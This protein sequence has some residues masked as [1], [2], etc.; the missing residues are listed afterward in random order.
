MSKISKIRDVGVAKKII[1][2]EMITEI[3]NYVRN[4]TI[5]TFNIN[6]YMNCY[7]I[8]Q[9]VADI[10]DYESDYLFNYH[11]KI[12]QGYIEECSQII[13][14]SS[15]DQLID[16]VIKQTEKIKF[17]IY[18]MNRIFTYLDRF[19]T[20]VQNRV[21]LCKNAIGFYKD[22]YFDFI[23]N[24]IYLEVNKLIKEVR[25]S[26]NKIIREKI[27]KILKIIYDI[28]L[29]VPKII[30]E[31]NKI[32]FIS[33]NANIKNDTYHLDKF[34]CFYINE[35]IKY[36][37]NKGNTE[38]KNMSAQEYIISQLKYLEEEKIRQNEF[39]NLK[40]YS[41]I[42]EIN[43]KYLIGDHAEE[44]AKKETG[45]YYMF[46]NKKNEE[47]TKTYQLFNFYPPSL[48]IIR[49]NFLLYIKKRG[50]AI[51]LNLDISKDPKKLI[52]EL[53]ILNKE[54][55]NIIS[56]CFG[57][58]KNFQDIKNKAFRNF[59]NKSIYSK[60]L[61]NYIDYCM[62]N[63]FRGKTQEEIEDILNDIIKLYQFL[64]SK[65]VFQLEANKKLSD[66]LARNASL[67]LNNEKMLIS[68]LKQ[69]SGIDYVIQMMKMIED[70]EKNSKELKE[71]KLSKSKG[72]PNG[73][74]FNV[75]VISLGAWEIDK[76][77]LEKI[78]IPIFLSSCM[79]DFENYY[80]KKN[81]GHKL[82][83]CLGYSKLEIQFLYLKI[84]NISVSTLIQYLILLHLEKYGA[85]TIEQLS[86]LLN[87]QVSTILKDIHGLVFNPTY[88]P[89]GD[90]NKGV[91]IGSFI[92]ETKNFKENDTISI[93][94]DFTVSYRK[95]NTLPLNLKK[96]EKEKKET[97]L[98]EEIIIKRYQK[99]I[100]Q[101]TI[102]R[103]MKSRIGQITTNDWLLNETSKQIDLF[104][105]Q[106]HQIKENIEELIEKNIIKRA[107]NNNS[108][109][110]YIA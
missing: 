49:N 65:L 9:Q 56:D 99:N 70:V 74:K 15:K 21:S 101:A 5:T 50:E 12:I 81:I 108:C 48:E 107:E 61:A 14:N 90:I 102:T 1:E 80:L 82:I 55:E 17:L 13:K 94:K 23:Q 71:Y 93:N 68:K 34:F 77:Y 78:E 24:E 98:A 72:S 105:A 26:N 96:S 36:A 64:S 28:D 47:L 46:I 35:T 69:E 86:F 20:T 97:E 79:K 7:V 109:Y 33:K 10:G 37:K 85:L 29:N 91:I 57:N 8:I 95:F 92:G 42:N 106:P 59:M 40:Y 53:I 30:K 39:I 89:N 88:N 100:L 31:N 76:K 87:C 11:N 60:Q 83:W 4:G 3:L 27:K 16:L 45:I 52:T 32:Y 62:R 73:I 84:K 6:A 51:Y 38:I 41:I 25:N 44:I 58:T 75:S 19:Y 43:Y 110:E 22:Y 18:M 54:M 66:R 63:S 103:I 104:K 67:S 2:K